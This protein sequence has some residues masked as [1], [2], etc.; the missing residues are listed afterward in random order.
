MILY[1]ILAT[2]LLI[3]DILLCLSDPTDPVVYDERL[4]FQEEEKAHNNFD[5]Y[6]FNKISKYNI[7]DTRDYPESD[8]LYVCDI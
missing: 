4:K 5:N 6:Q 2:V 8:Y 1:V 7:I 3:F